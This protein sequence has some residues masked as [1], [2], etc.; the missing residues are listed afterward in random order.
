MLRT[1]TGGVSRDNF[2]PV[3][4]A[5][6]IFIER[7]SSTMALA[8]ASQIRISP[9]HLGYGSSATNPAGSLDA[10]NRLLQKN[11][12]EHHMFW[13]TVAGHNHIV[14][15]VLT[16]LA[17]GGGPSELQRAYDD[18]VDIQRPLPLLDVDAVR[19]LGDP[20]QFRARMGQLDQYTNFLA[21]FG[22]QIDSKGVTAVVNESCFS[23]TPNA[24]SMFA[25]L[26]EGLYHPVIHLGLG[27][28]FDQPC[29]V[30]EALAQAAS[31]DSMGIE[32]F[33]RRSEKEAGRSRGEE[34]GKPLMQLL[35]GVRENATIRDAAH[36][37]QDGP[38]RVRDGVLGVAGQDIVSLAAQFRVDS[39]GLERALAEVINC[40][41]YITGS[42][43]RPGKARKLDFF[44]LHN[45]TA[46]L[47][48]TALVRQP[49]IS[50]GTKVRLVEW[51]ARLDLVWYA[52][53]GAVE[54]YIDD[55]INYTPA[56][57]VGMDWTALCQ[58]VNVVHDDGHLAKF[59]RAL[60][61]GQETSRPFECGEGADAFPV[62]GDM[63][64]KIA[65]MAYDSTVDLPIEKKWI[66]GV[67]FDENWAGVPELMV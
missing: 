1:A 14:H 26:F 36:G 5:L 67:G 46:S 60:K 11:H 65:E 32:T 17:L 59:V 48:V 55:V 47:F 9:E 16:V 6:Q 40:S 43:Q 18:G 52:A 2:I 24:E 62:K 51:K 54:L 57:S 35:H 27:I 37:F 39:Q 38:S 22:Q 19:Q 7:V 34:P 44:H 53:S 29:I 33:L 4:N 12:D 31:H 42:A 28:E 3:T 45:A 41:A 49:W 50:T 56:R 64:L 21:F 30:A 25:Q 8:T 66:W 61:N 63:W 15:S 10:A 58:A 13:R 20:N 23:Q